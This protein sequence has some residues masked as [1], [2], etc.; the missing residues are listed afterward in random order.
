MTSAEKRPGVFSKRSL[1]SEI[2]PPSPFPCWPQDRAS[3][4]AQNARWIEHYRD[5]K[6][7]VFLYRALAEVESDER[8]RGLFT[9]LA[10]VEDRHVE[11]WIEL[12]TQHD[13]PVPT[14]QPSRRTRLLAW[15]ARRFGPSTVLPM[16]LA[17]EGREVTAYF[18]LAR[19]TSYGPLHRA[20]LGI[21]VDSAEH[22]SEL[23]RLLGRDVEP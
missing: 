21:A 18:K 14:H 19:T 22:A 15:A 12:F 13:Q 1:S 20:A 6:D 4:V 9:R 23:G 11:R 2:H 7:A 17:E 10:A 3:R 8:H 16:I 5:E